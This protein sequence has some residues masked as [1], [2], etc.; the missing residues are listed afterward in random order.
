[1]V[2]APLS[3]AMEC[4]QRLPNDAE[5]A[6]RQRNKL[7]SQPP[8]FFEKVF[9]GQMP[10][11]QEKLFWIEERVREAATWTMYRNSLYLVVIEMT[12]PLIH[13][14]IRR[15][16]GRPCTDWN[17]LQQIKSELIGP[18]HEAVELFPAESRLI[19][20]TNEYHLWAH[21]KSG[22]RFPFGFATERCVL[23]QEP[24]QTGSMFALSTG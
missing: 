1:M 21:P 9:G 19:N 15:H 7:L 5:F 2:S 3:P 6:M 23:D 24:D 13:A 8:E 20:T 17:H 10:S 11:M 22:Y 4:F 16:D 14:C 18:E 12:A